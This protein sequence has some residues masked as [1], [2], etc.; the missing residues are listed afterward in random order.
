MQRFY[1]PCDKSNSWLSA[2]NIL[3]LCCDRVIGYI[4][5][6][7]D[8][9]ATCTVTTHTDRWWFNKK[10]NFN[11]LWPHCIFFWATTSSFNCSDEHMPPHVAALR[12][13]SAPSVFFR[14]LCLFCAPTQSTFI[15]KML[16]LGPSAPQHPAAAFL[17]EKRHYMDIDP[18]C[19]IP[20]FHLKNTH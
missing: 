4:R 18:K 3:Y 17:P 8:T 7:P 5:L 14:A 6:S 1:K 2:T 12:R 9:L 11:S 13:S 20:G 15:W 10:N 16:I 19:L